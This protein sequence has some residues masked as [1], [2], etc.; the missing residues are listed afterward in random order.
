MQGDDQGVHRLEGH[1]RG[2]QPR[3][4]ELLAQVAGDPGEPDDQGLFLAGGGCGDYAP[5]G[6]VG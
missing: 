5:G 1:R 3:A 6:G 2:A 4:Q